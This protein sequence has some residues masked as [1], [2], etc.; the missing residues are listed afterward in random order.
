LFWYA[1]V[2]ILLAPRFSS[3][4]QDGTRRD[5]RGAA[6]V[7]SRL[8]GPEDPVFCD[9]PQNLGYYLPGKAVRLWKRQTDL[10]PG[11]CYVVKAANAIDA[12][13][14]AP[15]RLLEYVARVGRRRFDEQTYLLRVYRVW[16]DREAVRRG[17]PAR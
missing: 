11:V 6:E 8:A 2:V 3:H 1:C 4:Y 9:R 17:E 12:P 5:F 15:G 7:V 10:P 13:L 14:A 16:P